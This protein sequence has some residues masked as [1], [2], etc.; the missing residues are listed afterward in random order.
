[1]LSTKTGKEITAKVYWSEIDRF[2][3]AIL[4]LV[5][6]KGDGLLDARYTVDEFVFAHPWLN[7]DRSIIQVFRHTKNHSAI[8]DELENNSL[9][10]SDELQNSDDWTPRNIAFFAMLEDVDH[11]I[12]ELSRALC[13]V[14]DWGNVLRWRENSAH[15]RP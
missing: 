15:F 6:A 14:S 5:I 7:N 1:M 13:H 2:A 8:F 10:W 12:N 11:R 4:S 3:H 9:G